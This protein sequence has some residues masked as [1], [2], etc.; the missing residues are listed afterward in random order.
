[1]IVE[2]KREKHRKEAEHK[3]EL[4]NQ[5]WDDVEYIDLDVDG[6]FISKCLA[7]KN[8]EEYDTRVQVPIDIPDRELLQY[9]KMAHERD[10]TFNDFVEQ[11]LRHAIEEVEA[12]RLTKQDAQDWLAKNNLPKFP[13]D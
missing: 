10:M 5:A 3:S 13:T 7:I 2:N 9:M 12:G 4:A 8:H 6:D 1:M 11:A